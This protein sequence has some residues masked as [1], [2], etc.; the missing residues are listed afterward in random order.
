MARL[1]QVCRVQRHR[2][3]AL[4]LPLAV[5]GCAGIQ[6][7]KV[8]PAAACQAD[9][10]KVSW[11]ASGTVMLAQIPLAPG[12]PDS[13]TDALAGEAVGESVPGAGTVER[14]VQTS[15]LFYLQAAGAS[16]EPV[17]KCA[18]VSVDQALPLSGVPECAG[19]RAFRTVLNV[20][21]TRWSAH[22]SLG[23]VQN[24][25]G[26]PISVQHGG[27][28]VQLEPQEA[29]TAF[30]AMDP[31]GDWQVESELSEGPACGLPDTLVPGSL[32]LQLN[33]HCGP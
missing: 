8:E 25:N 19:P 12:Q 26:V 15:T 1:R 33:P 30:A 14:Q 11:H 20:P 17:H 6:D 22:A 5:S 9:M 13:C 21:A 27:R 23:T 29:S 16:G 2:C 3:L 31:T 32:S 10:V 28:T 18:T 24:V 4:V 7:L